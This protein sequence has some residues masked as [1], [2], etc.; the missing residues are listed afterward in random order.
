MPIAIR[1]ALSRGRMR[2]VGGQ[3]QCVKIINMLFYFYTSHVHGK[4]KGWPGAMPHWHA[5]R[6]YRAAPTLHTH[7][8]L[9]TA[10]G[11]IDGDKANG[12]QR[13]PVYHPHPPVTHPNRFRFGQG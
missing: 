1:I 11:D 10:R 9:D 2:S 7:T 4:A 8:V 6:R 12:S 13:L 3:L 5:P